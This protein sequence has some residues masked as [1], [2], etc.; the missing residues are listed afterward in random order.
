MA[1]LTTTREERGEAIAR[2]DGQVKRV[3][4]FTYTVKSQSHEGE[5][6]YH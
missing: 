1:M 4:D 3:D 6:M 2:L 5:Y